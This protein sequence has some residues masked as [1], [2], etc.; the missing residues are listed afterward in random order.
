MPKYQFQV[1]ITPEY[2][3]QQSSPEAGVF[4][5]SYTVTI[6]NTGDTAAQ[7]VSRHW[8]ISDALGHT[9]EVKGL[10]V[11]GEQPLLRPGQSFQYHSGCQLR[12]PSGTMYGCYHCVAEDGQTFSCDIPLFILEATSPGAAGQP[13]S[14]RVLH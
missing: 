5:F 6:S 2:L 12:T 4:S 8:H 13:L 1:K 14:A 7:L 3:P 11:V 10:G 9:Q